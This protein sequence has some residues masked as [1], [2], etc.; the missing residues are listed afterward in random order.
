[1]RTELR[2]LK[3]SCGLSELP[4]I[5]D[6]VTPTSN[7]AELAARGLGGQDIHSGFRS[8]VG[9]MEKFLLWLSRLRLRLVEF[10]LY[11]G[12]ESD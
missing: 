5:K 2:A 12:N 6:R 9:I 3:C 10:L 7:K 11:S 1:M 8:Q 4:Y